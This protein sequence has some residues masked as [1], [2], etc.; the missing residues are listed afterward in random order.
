M[1]LVT[2][3]QVRRYAP[4]IAKYVTARQ[5]PPWFADPQLGHFSNDPTLTPQ[6]IAS[7]VAWANANVPEG[8]PHD[9][10]P[11]PKWTEGWNIPQPDR[12]IAMPKPVALPGAG[13]VEYTYEIVPTK[14]TNDEW[15]QMSEVRPSSRENV[16][17]AVVYIRPPDSKCLVA[18]RS[19]FHCRGAH[20]RRIPSRRALD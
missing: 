13:D 5:M 16:H 11:A 1:S 9:A 20:Q 3:D 17:H 4:V 6:E 15:I 12:I 18:R 7:L 10:P 2:Y 8:K 19:S 14:F